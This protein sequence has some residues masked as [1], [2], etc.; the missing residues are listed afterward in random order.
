MKSNKIRLILIIVFLAGLFGL[1]KYFGIHD[2]FN[3]ENIQSVFH[4][5]PIVG[6]LLFTL[7]FTVGLLIYIPGILF[8]VGAVY[9]LGLFYG[10][11]VTFF[12]ATSSCLI[13]FFLVRALGGSPL[14]DLKSDLAK[15][16][17][18]KIDSRPLLTVIFLRM[19]FH[20]MP[21]LNYAF[22]LS[23]IKARNY[24]LGTYLGLPI[25]IFLYCT[26]FDV[27]KRFVV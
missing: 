3:V 16:I 1:S 5:H 11:L 4:L 20:T 22:A 27:V 14:Q 25:P 21:A 15:K 24:I 8:L 26:F 13:I 18:S 23:G 9:S 12:A 10:G 19:L 7:L 17:L 6:T 2:E